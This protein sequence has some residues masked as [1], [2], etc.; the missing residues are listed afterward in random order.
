MLIF[1]LTLDKKT[2]DME[3]IVITTKEDKIKKW[4]D[5]IQNSGVGVTFM[6]EVNEASEVGYYKC[7]NKIISLGSLE[8]FTK[9][10]DFQYRISDVIAECN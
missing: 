3:T 1:H 8:D 4:A 6:Y 7:Q 10:S 2:R 9:Y 5:T